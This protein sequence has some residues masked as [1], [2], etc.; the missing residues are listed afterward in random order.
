MEQATRRRDNRGVFRASRRTGVVTIHIEHSNPA[1][2]GVLVV[3][4]KPLGY[5]LLIGIDSIQSLDDTVLKPAGDMHLDGKK[6]SCAAIR[7]DE[8]DFCA[9]FDHKE[10]V[11]K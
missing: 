10:K 8:Y 3:Q 7:I 4:E 6:E 1:E 9:T 2:V 11:R 5:N